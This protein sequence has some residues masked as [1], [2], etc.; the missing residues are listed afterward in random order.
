[1]VHSLKWANRI[2]DEMQSNKFYKE[3]S[4]FM[5]LTYDNLHL[6]LCQ[7]ICKRHL[8]LFFKRIRKNWKLKNLKYYA[9][10]EYG[11]KH[12]RPHYHIIFLGLPF[13]YIQKS[14]YYLKTLKKGGINFELP[15]WDKGIC[16]IQSLCPQNVKYTTGY[17]MKKLKKDM[18]IYQD[19]GVC[20]PFSLI[21][22]GV[23]KTYITNLDKEVKKDDISYYI[24]KGTQKEYLNRYYR[25]KLEL[26]PLNIH[27]TNT[28]MIANRFNYLLSFGQKTKGQLE[29]I[30]RLH[31]LLKSDDKK[32][33]SIRYLQNQIDIIKK[34]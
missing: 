25:E 20:P 24:S 19:L 4:Y 13:H 27:Y 11:G 9:V 34:V 28:D 6:P 12:G 23:G 22:K 31:T 17:I 14:A 1:M 8:Q 15:E 10:G 30:E 32:L 7:S 29:E 21:S 5:T 16:N 33:D 2:T 3:N 18:D 26:E